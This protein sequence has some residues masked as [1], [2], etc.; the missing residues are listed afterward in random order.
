[1]ESLT[2]T[3]RQHGHIILLLKNSINTRQMISPSPQADFQLDALSF[4]FSHFQQSFEWPSSATYR[5]SM[6]N[7]F[8]VANRNH[9]KF[10]ERL[11]IWQ[12]LLKDQKKA[13]FLEKANDFTQTFGPAGENGYLTVFSELFVKNKDPDWQKI[14]SDPNEYASN[15]LACDPR[16]EQ[17]AKECFNDAFN[18]NGEMNNNNFCV[19]IPGFNGYTLDVVKTRQ[20]IKYA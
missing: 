1:M 3:I 11:D 17:T 19:H 9:P 6:W 16:L 10:N 12:K 4:S 8:Q 20:R 18:D 7:S 5:A 2:R 13:A 15:R 14:W